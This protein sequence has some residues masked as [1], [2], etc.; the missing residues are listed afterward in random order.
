MAVTVKIPAPNNKTV[1]FKI[2]GTAPYVQHKFSEK[3]KHEMRAKQEAGTTGAKTTRKRP[4]KDFN[5]VYENAKYKPTGQKWPN[6]AIPATAFKAALIAACRLI[7]VKMTIGKQVLYVES[8]GYDMDERI[9][10][11]R[12][13]KG[14]PKP[15]EQALRV[16]NGNPDLRVRPLWEAG[17][18]CTLRITFDADQLSAEDIGNLLL[19]A[20]TQVGIGDGR[21]A[22]R[23]CAGIGWGAF[24]IKIK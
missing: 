13:T 3:I 19:R 21:N 6:G 16:A 1:V 20:G 14:K 4:P 7:D 17:W 24:T 18:E 9:P 2:V 15:F 11:V 5:D 22:S 8:D 23:N 12:I 10:L